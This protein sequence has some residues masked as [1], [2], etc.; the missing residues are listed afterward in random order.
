[1][2]TK[3]IYVYLENGF[4]SEWHS[5]VSKSTDMPLLAT[6]MENCEKLLKSVNFIVLYLDYPQPW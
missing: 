6:L 1:M 3:S 4:G 5:N 2:G